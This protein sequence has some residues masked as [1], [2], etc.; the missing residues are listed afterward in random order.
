MEPSRIGSYAIEK[1]IGSGGMGTVYLGKH[2]ETD[3]IVAVKVLPA[4]FSRDE[5][6][7]AR[8]SR[9]IETLKQLSNPYVVEL[10]DSGIDENETYFYAMEYVDG[11]TLSARL[12]QEKRIPWRKV[13]EISIQICAALKAAH[14]AGFVH[15]DLKPSN[16]IFT[17]DGTVKLTDFGVA[18]VFASGRLTVTGGI[19]GT[20]EY[21]SPEQAEGKRATKKSDL[22]SLGAVMYAMLT[23]KPPFSGK[24][25]LDIVQKHKYAQF[26][27]PGLIVPDMPHWL[28]EI[29]CQLM[30][31]DPDKRIPDAYVLSR[32]LREVLKKVELSMQEQ[33]IASDG[34]DG[35]A[36]T[37]AAPLRSDEPG[38]ATL[39]R[40]LVK[41]EVENAHRPSALGNFFNNTWVLLGMLILLIVGGFY[42]F[43]GAPLTPEEQFEKGVALMALPEGA[44]W[45]EARKKY[46][47][48][49]M[50]T[51]P[52]LW[53]KK[54][55]PYLQQVERY[56]L[57]KT[58]NM[59]SRNALRKNHTPQ[60]EIERIFL[61]SQSYR[62]D[63]D[64]SRAERTLGALETLIQSDSK[65][66]E[67]HLLAQQLLKEIRE[68]QKNTSERDALLAASMDRADAL[69]KDGKR[70]E[71]ENVWKSVVELYGN[72]AGVEAIVKRAQNQLNESLQKQ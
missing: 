69:V 23:G 3:Q 25:T 6:A 71:A 1:K 19:I 10:Y 12:R 65:Y 61:L 47:Q 8:F 11:D 67:F 32:N 17:Q 35:T 52:D 49:L 63:G 62:D 51:N 59:S 4:S 56:E 34:Y 2:V 43:G 72:D 28:E 48:P 39:M 41:A 18:Q 31:K 50:E 29:V 5:G 38:V 60:G 57:M 40:D 27:R 70:S 66:E 45:I 30:E 68:Q 64:F 36:P 21:M 13:I 20:A 42:W 7:V 9:E 54:V 14:D 16:L 15:R 58:L 37:A 26:D 22:Y 55:E 53:Q 33:T 44:E 46:F 24:T